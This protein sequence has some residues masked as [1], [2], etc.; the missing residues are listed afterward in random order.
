MNNNFKS[1]DCANHYRNRKSEHKVKNGGDYHKANHFE[2][3]RYKNKSCWKPKNIEP[4]E[5]DKVFSCK[6]VVQCVTAHSSLGHSRRTVF[7]SNS[8]MR[9][10]YFSV[11]AILSRRFTNVNFQTNY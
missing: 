3:V 9:A 11:R 1:N 6:Y 5:S 2:K 8:L 10:L 7:E 4:L